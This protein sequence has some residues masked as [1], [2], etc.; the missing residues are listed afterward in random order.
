MPSCPH[1]LAHHSKAALCESVDFVV[2]AF[3][4]WRRIRWPHIHPCSYQSRPPRFGAL[5]QGMCHALVRNSQN[6]VLHG[7]HGGAPEGLAVWSLIGLSCCPLLF[8]DIGV[9]WDAIL[10]C[11][12][13]VRCQFCSIGVQ[14]HSTCFPLPVVVYERC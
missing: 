4:Y 10:F 2:S 1:F 7:V 13:L 12:D 11:H 9:L 5:A 8:A 14:A 3:L 6:G